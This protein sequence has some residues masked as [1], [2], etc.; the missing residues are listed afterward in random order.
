MSRL[1]VAAVQNDPDFGRLERNLERALALIPRG[2]DLAVLPELFATGYQ[3]RSRAEALR[4][5]E[6]LGPG[7][8]PGP[9]R[10]ALADFAAAG[11]TTLVAGLAERDGDRLYNGAVLVRPDGT[12]E[13]YRKVHLFADEKLVFDPGDLGFPVFAACG[14]TVGLMVCF[15]WLFPEAA[16]SLALAGA[17]ILC[18]PANLVLP[19]CPDA[20]VTRCQENRVF[21]ITSDRVGSEHRTAQRLDFIGM[22]QVVS[23]LGEVLARLGGQDAGAAT[24]A[25]DP[26]DVRRQITPRNHV[27]DDRRPDQYRL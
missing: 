19:W 20:M 25:I 24:A 12:W 1:Q 8:A 14:T 21:A 27:F 3:F 26:Q 11:G 15:D 2:C 10:A 23:P 17:R 13:R 22:S 6:E 5:A 16:R 4:H 9:I 18:H 7:S